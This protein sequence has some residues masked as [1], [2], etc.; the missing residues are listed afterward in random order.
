[1]RYNNILVHCPNS[2]NCETAKDYKTAGF[3]ILFFFFR[4][5]F[6]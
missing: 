1:M 4:D 5:K 2:N 3:N 6:I